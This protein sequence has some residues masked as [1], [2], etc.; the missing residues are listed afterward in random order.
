M[1]DCCSSPSGTA[2]VPPRKCLCPVCGGEGAGVSMQTILHHIKR[3]WQWA[4][5]KQGYYFCE[6]PACA[7]VYFGEDGSLIARDEVRGSV[8]IKEHSPAAP[9]CYCFGVTRAD[10]LS[11]PA[12]R[13]YV[14]DKTRGGLCSCSIR[15]P[16]GRC[17]LKDFP[18]MAIEYNP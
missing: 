14:V 12:I 13:E 8:G 1:H 2:V 16:S 10:A 15:N 3:G 9:V 4:A 11:D 6:D 18:A 17:C 5:R 7:V